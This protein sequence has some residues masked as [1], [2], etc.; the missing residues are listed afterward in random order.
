MFERSSNTLRPELAQPLAVLYAASCA[1]TRPAPCWNTEYASVPSDFT[2]GRA[3]S[4]KRHLTW[5][6]VRFGFTSSINAT[7]PLVTAAACDV[8]DIVKSLKRLSTHCG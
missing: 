5:S 2:A 1:F 7:T 8:P 4:I 3:L 6:G